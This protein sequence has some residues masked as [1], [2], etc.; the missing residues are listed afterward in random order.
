MHQGKGWLTRPKSTGAAPR[1]GCVA[2]EKKGGPSTHDPPGC[3]AITGLIGE[4]KAE[5]GDTGGATWQ[6]IRGPRSKGG[7]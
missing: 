6:S 5:E 2:E 3:M 4:G 7:A 1:P